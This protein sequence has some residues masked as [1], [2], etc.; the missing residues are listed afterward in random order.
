MNLVY[1]SCYKF[2]N[3]AKFIIQSLKCVFNN[4]KCADFAISIKQ[5]FSTSTKNK[6][7]KKELHLQHEE[8]RLALAKSSCHFGEMLAHVIKGVISLSMPENFKKSMVFLGMH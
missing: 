2:I 1:F 4:F 6:T 5:L 8:Y 7:R 3:I